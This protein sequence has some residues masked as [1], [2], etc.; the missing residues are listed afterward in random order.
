MIWFTGDEHFFHRNIIRYCN[1]PFKSH[2]DM[3]T[4]IIKRHN[5]VVKGDD[6]VY[7]IGDFAMIGSSQSDKLKGILNSL[8]GS[9]ELILGNHDELKP[10]KY[11]D[12]GFQRVHTSLRLHIYEYVI[13]LHHDPS[14]Y[15][16]IESTLKEEFWKRSCIVHGHIHTLYR[17]M[18]SRR[19]I[20]VGVDVHNFTPINFDTIK[21]QL[22]L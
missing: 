6:L 20:N 5:S 4:T 1:R 10:Q 7:H 14:V 11:I 15:C 22:E 19:C 18:P 12:I 8:N 17:V 2:D 16:L 21:S 9:H 3:K 13:E